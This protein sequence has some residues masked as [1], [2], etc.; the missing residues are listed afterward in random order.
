MISDS[1]SVYLKKHLLALSIEMIRCGLREDD[2]QLE[3][4]RHAK[5]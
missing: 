1:I 3:V 4:N 5:L 2:I